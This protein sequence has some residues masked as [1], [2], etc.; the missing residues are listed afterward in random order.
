MCGVLAPRLKSSAVRARLPFPESCALAWVATRVLIALFAARIGPGDIPY[1]FRSVHSPDPGR[2]P[3]EEYPYLLAAPL[4]VLEHLVGGDQTR[5]IVAFGLLLLS[6]DAALTWYLVRARARW[7]VAFWL[8]CGVVLSPIVLTRLDL[9]P[10]MM[11]AAAA[12][13]LGTSDRVA[14]ALTGLATAIKLGPVVLVAG[15]VGHWR[16]A[17]TWVRVGWAAGTMA[18]AGLLTL[19]AAGP[20][21]LLSPVGYQFHRGLE[22]EALAAIPLY[23]LRLG[24]PQRWPVR[25]AASK[26]YEIFGPGVAGLLTV[27]T[28][29]IACAGI[30]I[31]GLVAWRALDHRAPTSPPASRAAWLTMLIA[32]LVT[33]KVLSPQYLLWVCPLVAVMLALDVRPVGAPRRWVLPAIGVGLLIAAAATTVVYP[34]RISGFVSNTAPDALAYLCATVRGV[35][36]LGIGVLAA[37]EMCT[38]RPVPH[39]EPNPEPEPKPEPIFPVYRE[40]SYVPVASR[41]R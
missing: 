11:V 30:A 18:L 2:V 23:W 8:A 29:A 40:V 15:L 27:T 20:A 17:R 32:V 35:V 22:V 28:V 14:G 6:C 37:V 41:T 31:L 16:D 10:G 13:A 5:F 3:L 26:S 24:D 33:S 4:G 34:V 39:N 12:A 36:L 1:Y 25:F 38:P 21:R 7:A 19:V 9:L